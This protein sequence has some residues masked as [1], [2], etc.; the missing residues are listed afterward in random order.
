MGQPTPPSQ[1]GRCPIRDDSGAR[2]N[3]AAAGPE[4]T[5]FALLSGPA[6]RDLFDADPS[7]LL[8]VRNAFDD[9]LDAVLQQR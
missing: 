6:V 8:E 9:F 4:G 3:L 1:S 7:D 5:S 2:K